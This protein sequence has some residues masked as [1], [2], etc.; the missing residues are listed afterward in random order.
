MVL[1]SFSVKE[2]ELQAGTKIRTTRLFTPE[3]WRQW[4]STVP[5]NAKTLLDGWWKPRTKDGYLI[6]ERPGVDLYRIMFK[7]RNG[8]LWPYLVDEERS[9]GW[10][11]AISPMTADE[12]KQYML[13][14]GFEDQADE[15]RKFFV[16]H[17]APLDGKVFQ[18]IAFPPVVH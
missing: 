13:E 17:Y 11:L 18:S 14:E 2:A 12:F 4:Q 9:D 16:E 3:K 15:F 6:F 1:L 8:M 5:P 10:A 7:D